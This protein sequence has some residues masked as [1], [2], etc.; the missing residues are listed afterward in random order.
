RVISTATNLAA[1]SGNRIDLL[2]LFKDD[3][4]AIHMAYG[5]L[6]TSSLLFTLGFFYR[7]SSAMLFLGLVSFHHHAVFYC[8]ASDNYIRVVA[9]SMAFAPAANRLSLDS[10]IYGRKRKTSITLAEPWAQRLLQLQ[11]CAI[12]FQC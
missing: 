9:F 2:L 8:D 10:L 1:Q 5:I 3:T 12:Y 6:L 7:F 4:S 11:L